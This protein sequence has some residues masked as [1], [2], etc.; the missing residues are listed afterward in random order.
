MR[1]GDNAM[2]V[3]EAAVTFKKFLLSMVVLIIFY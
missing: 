2:S 3:P 1:D